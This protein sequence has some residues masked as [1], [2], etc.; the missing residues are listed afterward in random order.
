MK[1]TLA[2]PHPFVIVAVLLL[3]AAVA[4]VVVPGGEF[5][6][7]TSPD[8][9]ETVVEES[10]RYQ[11]NQ[12]QVM[13]LFTAPLAGFVKLADIIERQIAG[14]LADFYLDQ[15]QTA[16]LNLNEAVILALRVASL[17]KVYG[18]LPEDSKRAL[19]N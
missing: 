1:T 13:Q 4:T 17:G 9:S 2:V 7:I 12:P 5:D 19:L 8:G 10:F 3:L 6:R 18:H 15:S 14:A 16:S 11:E